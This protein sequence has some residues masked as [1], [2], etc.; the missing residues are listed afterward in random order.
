MTKSVIRKE[1]V[2]QKEIKFTE[3]NNA[4]D[5]PKKQEFYKRF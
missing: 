5:T 2:E 4:Q 1:A 3:I